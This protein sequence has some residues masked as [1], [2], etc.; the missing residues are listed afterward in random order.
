MNESVPWWLCKANLTQ[1]RIGLE[2]SVTC[3]PESGQ[4]AVVGLGSRFGAENAKKASL[5]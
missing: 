1:D 5:L 4:C 3:S 2:L